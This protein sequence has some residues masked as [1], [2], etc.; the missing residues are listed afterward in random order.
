MKMFGFPFGLIA[1]F[2]AGQVYAHPYSSGDTVSVLSSF[3]HTHPHSLTLGAA[4]TLVVGLL[5][6]A[7]CLRKL[8]NDTEN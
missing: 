5:L 3:L 8:S 2:F 6:G 1:S 7:Q 4:L